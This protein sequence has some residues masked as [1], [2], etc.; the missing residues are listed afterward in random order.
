MKRGRATTSSCI[1]SHASTCFY[2]QPF[3]CLWLDSDWWRCIW[4]PGPISR[5]LPHSLY[6]WRLGVFIVQRV[7]RQP[8]DGGLPWPWW[9]SRASFRNRHLLTRWLTAAR[10]GFTTLSLLRYFAACMLL[11]LSV[12]FYHIAQRCLSHRRKRGSSWVNVRMVIEKEDLFTCLRRCSSRVE[13]V[14]VRN[15]VWMH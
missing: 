14:S 2:P 7:T 10:A 11:F 12:R 8:A 6:K 9:T 1:Q 4:G 3:L 15:G 13:F 5:A